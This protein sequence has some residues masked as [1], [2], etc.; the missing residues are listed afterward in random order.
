MLTATRSARLRTVAF[1]K[2]AGQ[3]AITELTIVRS[4]VFEA[5]AEGLAVEGARTGDVLDGKLDIVDAA[6]IVRGG[7]DFPFRFVECNDGPRR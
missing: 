7:M 3:A 6:V 4:I 2:A 5:P 1:G